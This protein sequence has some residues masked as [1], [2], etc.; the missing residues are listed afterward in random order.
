MFQLKFARSF[1]V[2][3]SLPDALSGLRELA[4]NFR[5]TWHP[6]TQALFE[7]TDPKLWAEVEHN[8]AQLISRLTTERKDQL[9]GDSVYLA[10]LKTCV[11]ELHRYLAADQTWFK[12]Q[13]PADDNRT[14]VAYFCFEFGISESL[15][16]YSGGLGVLAGDHLK[17]ASD[18]GVPLVAVGL[19]YSRGYF[20]QSL[21]PDNW[22]V[23][24]YPNYDFFQMP[25]QL[26]RDEND[27]PL[28]IEVEFPDRVVTCHIWRAMVGRISL[29]LLDSNVLSNAQDDKQITDALYG[30]DEQMRLRQEMILGIGGMR[31]LKRLGIRPS[32]CHLNEGHAGFLTI[33]R[34]NQIMG[35]EG[36]DTKTA[37]QAMV[38]GNI[39]TTHTPV[40]AGFDVFRPEL[41]N[42]YL[43]KEIEGKLKMPMEEFVRMGRF[44]P[45][46]SAE[47]LNMAVLA[48]EN[49]NAVNGVS[50]LHAEVSRGM[51]GERWPQY[52]IQEVP[53]DSVTNGIHTATWMAPQMVALFD[54]HFSRAWRD[55]DSDYK[56]WQRVEEIPD[57]ELWELRENLRG[58]FI[59]FLRKQIVKALQAK[60]ASRSEISSASTVLDPRVLTIGFARR[61]ATY[62]R[63]H[64]LMTDR[65]RLLSILHNS[66]RP[67]QF[68]FAGK[69]HPRD[70]GGK[71]IIQ[72]INNFI[73]QG[74]ARGRMVFL[75]DY[76]MEIARHMV[77]GVDVWLN[78]PRRPM[79]ASG[80]S[81]MK[82][83]PN[84]GLNASVLDGWWAEAYN[85]EV[86]WA[87]GDG[88]EHA[89]PAHQDWLDSRS[90]YQLLEQE[91]VPKFYSRGESGIPTQW[92]EMVKASMAQH[93]PVYSTA[94]MVR[95]YAS[96]Y[97]VPC[98]ERHLKLRA[99]HCAEAGKAIEWRGKV[100]QAWPNVHIED[101]SDTTAASNLV[102]TEFE[103]SARVQL[104]G[105]SAE[106][107]RVQ[108]L[109]G[110]ATASRE[111]T[112]VQV[113]DMEPQGDGNYRLRASCDFVG[114]MGYCL[115]V[116]PH[117]D[118]VSV[119]HELPLVVWQNDAPGSEAMKASLLQ[120]V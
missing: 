10:R 56:L 99:D 23:E 94:R 111:L 74:G 108:V 92:V 38:A 7:E 29:Y 50:K 4:L 58:D 69:S 47:D 91:I 48:M 44:Q 32:T 86:G 5:W 31:A 36:V 19:L 95:E 54:R 52:P 20:R 63:A 84:G 107:V 16:I 33:E 17:A 82:V 9:A 59:R 110:K 26:M 42:T 101:V 35:E 72:E 93:A 27:V 8:P 89:D 87:I 103:I 112:D 119:A 102:G 43:K 70:D 51:F 109:V 115:R 25:L 104:G 49:S 85:N 88:T 34:L 114:Q 1:E 14:K 98:S 100:R 76:D 78:N 65:E 117:H 105:L 28:S 6:E 73:Q 97:Y 40:P 18:L 2:V 24:K 71:N 15:P 53:V 106:D 55:S 45:D 30:G 79:E 22:Q 3:S 41:L 118:L 39:F 67:V 62:K 81:G 96:R 61:F 13:Y 21:S 46:N 64:L 12:S 77:R 90:L 116:I 113:H 80:T 75:E 60:N 68:V 66:E 83:V 57:Q 37:R 11:E 120:S